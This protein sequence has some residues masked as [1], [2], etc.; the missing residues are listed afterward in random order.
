MLKV[1]SFKKMIEKNIYKHKR[2]MY[3][4]NVQLLYIQTLV[5]II[6]ETTKYIIFCRGKKASNT[7]LRGKRLLIFFCCCG[8]IKMKTMRLKVNS[9]G[10]IKN[11]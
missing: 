11:L 5:F 1:K 3:L 10:K 7:K 8:E 6:Q 9:K 4:L 2:Y